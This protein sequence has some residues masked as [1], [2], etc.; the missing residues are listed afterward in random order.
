M[1][2]YTLPD[3][4]GTGATVPLSITSQPCKFWQVTAVSIASGARLGDSLTTANRG[5]PIGPSG[6]QFSP[7]IAAPLDL[8]DLSEQYAY[9]AN[10]DVI[11]VAYAI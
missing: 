3:I 10:G 2:I 5:I 1:K 8:Y 6:G 9:V 7:P 11:S 4:T